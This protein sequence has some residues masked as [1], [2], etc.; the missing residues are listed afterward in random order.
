MKKLIVCILAATFAVNAFAE[1]LTRE[2]A[3]IY[4]GEFFSN[5]PKSALKI[6][7]TGSD[8]AFYVIERSGGGFL[9]L[10]GETAV[11]PLIGYSYEGKFVTENMPE[12]VNAWFSSL[13]RDVSE[14]RRMRVPQSRK[15]SLEWE[16]LGI[17]TRAGGSSR[18]IESALWDQG[19]PYNKYCPS[20][21]GRKA[22]T[23][24]VAT[25]MAITMRH[26][27][28]PAHGYGYLNPY[29]TS[30]ERTH[31][32]GFSIE[33][34]TY[35]WDKMPLKDVGR[36]DDYAKDQIARLMYDCGVMIQMDYSPSGSG[37]VSMYM[38]A[39]MA[40]HFAY[41]AE[42][43]LFRKSMYKPKEWIALVKK[44]LDADRLVF[45]SAQD[46]TGQ[47]GHAFVI[48]GY[49]ENDLLH[50]NWGWSGAGNAYYNLDLE[51]EG[52]RFSAD[53]GAVLG[54]V[55]DPGR[56]RSA[57]T[58]LA[59][60]GTGLSLS[61]GRIEEGKTFSIDINNITNYGN[62]DFSGP[63]MVVLTDEN[64]KVKTQL[65]TPVGVTVQ[66]LS[67][68]SVTLSGC[69]MEVRP[70]F[71]DHVSLAYKD[72]VTSEYTVMRSDV[73]NESVG[74]LA[75]IP[76]FIAGKSSYSAG[77]SFEFKLFKSGEKFKS[78]VWYFDGRQ[79][80]EDE[81]EVVLTAGTHEVK[82]ILTKTSGI[83]TLVRELIVR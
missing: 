58:Y 53:H 76:N 78:V 73:E 75:T 83:E 74:G 62:A 68:A 63:L 67:S 82:A 19:S 9:V 6:V 2:D 15:V 34:H 54:L 33:D 51:V 66:A 27:R 64:D 5:T 80:S 39:A 31:I 65:C 57:L 25:A 44:E 41:S 59:L 10:S 18:L 52:Y 50:V 81:D 32:E 48:D 37:A 20:S 77:E 17:R 1:R 40:D 23:G 12:H 3:L 28:Y 16:T 22:V 45:Y 11:P 24:C 79:V 38:P 8:D 70:E 56:S 71:K 36:A 13:A 49:D 42:A 4:A 30:T 61:S 43:M 72:P 47:G 46:A 14:L 29:T 55:P 35:D 60:T 26:N 69:R 21:N 7:W